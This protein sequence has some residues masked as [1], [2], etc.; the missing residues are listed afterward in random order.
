[1]QRLYHR[2]S[3]TPGLI[4]PIACIALACAAGGCNVV[5]AFLYKFSPPP[6]VD[7]LYKLK[8]VPTVILV[9]N[10][11]NPDLSANESEL[12]ARY[13][14]E[15]MNDKKLVTVVP[16]EKVLDLKN[17]RP[18]DY[19]QMTIPEIGRAVGAEQVLYVDLQASAVGTMAANVMYQGKGSAYV[20]IVDCT[21]GDTLWPTD[22]A[23]GFGVNYATPEIKGAE[24]GTYNSVRDQLYNGFADAIVKLFY[25]HYVEDTPQG[26]GQ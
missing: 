4:F 19:A 15:K 16:E 5:G 23:D 14:E 17:N 1:M 10:F 2:S 21:S 22:N 13:V 18:K 24:N 9:E 7:A 11:R 8:N 20:K 25:K 6:Q 3:R 26:R 12:L